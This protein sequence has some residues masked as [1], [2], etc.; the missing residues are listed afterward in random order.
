MTKRALTTRKWPLRARVVLAVSCVLAGLSLAPGSGHA[1]F[2]GQ[3]GKIAFSSGG[4]IYTV[5][6]DGS[7]LVNHTNDPA[8]D[9]DPAFS[10]D[11]TKL[12]F[13]SFR[14]GPQSVFTMNL[15]GSGLMRLVSLPSGDR[16][17]AYSPDGSRIAFTSFRDGNAEIYSMGA[18][19]CG[20]TRLTSDPAADVEPAVSPDGSKIAFS[21][22]RDVTTAA[23][24]PEV[25]SMN[26]DG[27]G[28]T[29]LTFGDGTFGSAEPAFSPDGSKI[30]FPRG[31]SSFSFEI[32]TMNPDGSS[33]AALTTRVPDPDVRTI[34]R[35]PAFSPDGTKVAFRS[36]RGGSGR[37]P[38]GG[39]EAN[40]DIFTVDSN[41]SNIRPVTTNPSVKTDVDWGV[42]STTP[43]TPALPSCGGYPPPSGL[44]CPAGTSAGVICEK[45]GNTVRITGTAGKDTIVGTQDFR[46][47][48]TCGAGDDVVRTG[49]GD[50]EIH[51]GP[52][53]DRIDSGTGKD[54]VFGDAGKDRIIAGPGND[55]ISGGS[56]NDRISGGSGNDS[57][58]SGSGSD[59]INGGSGRDRIS[60]GSGKD[61]ISARDRQRDRI[62]CGSSR[63]A[64]VADRIDRVARDCERVRRR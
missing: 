6:P 4:E 12:A 9:T 61:R 22:F 54:L 63:D 28:Q 58:K 30:V 55:S 50:D 19:G 47:V 48:V 1:A 25:Y 2:S 36:T 33:Q 5:A 43:L 40:S 26:A 56:G 14:D 16:E 15:D 8:F 31:L 49:G 42:R 37:P 11:G 45:V 57:I 3:N 24:Q 38:G 13:S 32:W 10:P 46:D 39:G 52:G 34:D 27:T 41:G 29:R 62:S 23:A 20:L 59:R 21:S 17:P 7:G 51:C 44:Q 18:N 60:G 35:E 53:N 64:L